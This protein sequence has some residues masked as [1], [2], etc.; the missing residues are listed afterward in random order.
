MENPVLHFQ[1][2]VI[3]T[4]CKILA[5]GK[6]CTSGGRVHDW[7]PLCKQPILILHGKGVMGQDSI[8]YRMIR[9]MR[10][11]CGYNR[12]ISCH[13]I[14]LYKTYHDKLRY[15]GFINAC[16]YVACT[17]CIPNVMFTDG[18]ERFSKMLKDPS[19]WEHLAGSMLQTSGADRGH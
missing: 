16:A 10:S 1:G 5:A 11:R 15:C 13:I 19:G 2:I 7:F 18:N 14:H 6:Q 4:I 12:G 17:W 8:W 9:L 3:G